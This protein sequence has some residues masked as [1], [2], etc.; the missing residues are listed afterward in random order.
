MLCNY[1][2]EANQVV[3]IYILQINNNNV[4]SVQL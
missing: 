2:Y 3:Y 4:E 1:D